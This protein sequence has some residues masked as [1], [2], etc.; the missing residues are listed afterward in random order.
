LVSQRISY[1]LMCCIIFSL[2][3]APYSFALPLTLHYAILFSYS[4]LLG[5][6]D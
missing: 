2:G 4:I 6:T 3:Y 1:H 5:F